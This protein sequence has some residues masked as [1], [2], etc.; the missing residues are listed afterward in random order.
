MLQESLTRVGFDKSYWA[1]AANADEV[2]ISEPTIADNGYYISMKKGNVIVSFFISTVEVMGADVANRLEKKIR[3][4]SPWVCTD[5]QEKDHRI[6]ELEEEHESFRRQGLDV[7]V[8]VGTAI[9]KEFSTKRDVPSVRS[10]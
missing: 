7:L 6:K 1:Y 9:A 4:L 10:K 8:R 3:E 5:C 2:T